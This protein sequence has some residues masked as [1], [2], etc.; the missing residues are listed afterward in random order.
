VGEP[1]MTVIGIWL[2][3]QWSQT[4]STI[5]HWIARDVGRTA[6]HRFRGL[7]PAALNLLVGCGLSQ[8]IVFYDLSTTICYMRIMPTIV[9]VRA[10]N[11]LI[12]T[13]TIPFGPP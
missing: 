11:G 8:I 2:T 9:L 4:I 13:P 6:V 5:C 10:I 1:K 7:R 3:A 12:P